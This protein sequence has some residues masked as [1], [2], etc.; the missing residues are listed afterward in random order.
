M[1]VL[2]VEACANDFG[3]QQFS[4]GGGPASDFYQL[5]LLVSDARTGLPR[6]GI[7]IGD[8]ELMSDGSAPTNIL[9]MSG[10]GSAF[11][12]HGMY[13]LANGGGDSLPNGPN[14]VGL[15][16]NAGPDHGLTLYSIE[17]KDRVHHPDF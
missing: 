7:T 6:D 12:A 10:A 17:I 16:V 14:C 5:T 15:F 2:K 11:A 3:H 9:Q 8:V 4:F 13:S 1:G